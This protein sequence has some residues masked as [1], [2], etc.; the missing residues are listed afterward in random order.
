MLF[1]T[2]FQKVFQKSLFSFLVMAELDG[3]AYA[4]FCQEHFFYVFS[5]RHRRLSEIVQEAICP[6]EITSRNTTFTRVCESKACMF[7]SE[8][9][10]PTPAYN[11]V[12]NTAERTASTIGDMYDGVTV[13]FREEAF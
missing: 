13:F 11:A 6:D 2:S 5:F 4:V 9:P 12:V 1:V 8:H 7:V 10:N 3:S